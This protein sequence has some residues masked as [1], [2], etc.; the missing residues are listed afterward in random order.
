MAVPGP[1]GKQPSNS[2]G[3]TWTATSNIN[4]RWDIPDPSARSIWD[5]FSVSG[6]LTV[7]SK[8]PEFR[9]GFSPYLRIFT[10]GAYELAAEN[11]SLGP[12][13]IAGT[14][15]EIVLRDDLR[16]G[17]FALLHR[18]VVSKADGRS[19]YVVRD[20]PDWRAYALTE[21]QADYLKKEIGIEIE[22]YDRALFVRKQ[23]HKGRSKDPFERLLDLVGEDCVA[24][25]DAEC[26]DDS[27]DYEGLVLELVAMIGPTLED[28]DVECDWNGLERD[29]GRILRLTWVGGQIEAQLSGSDY[30]DGEPFLAA[31]N[32]MLRARSIPGHFMCLGPWDS[33][34]VVFAYVL[35]EH[36]AAVEALDPK[37][38][39]RRR[40]RD[41]DT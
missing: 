6:G 34:D 31:L 5:L 35:P 32:Q 24:E 29:D 3:R 10:D 38:R 40:M 1:F 19:L 8:R 37:K 30:I 13:K 26:V 17:V 28:L 39:R 9:V 36:A 18:H 41:D 4:N 20:W 21:P 25:M 16:A 7:P 15:G 2:L 23:R 27:D 14:D 11:R 33:H 12:L 22:L